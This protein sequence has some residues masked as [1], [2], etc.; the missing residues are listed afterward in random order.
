MHSYID[1]FESPIIWRMKTSRSHLLN[2]RSCSAVICP[3]AERRMS[4]IQISE[5][6][7]GVC[8]Q[9]SWPDPA[10]FPLCRPLSQSLHLLHLRVFC[11]FCRLLQRLAHICGDFCSLS[12]HQV[13]CRGALHQVRAV[14]QPRSIHCQ[15]CFAAVHCTGDRV[16]IAKLG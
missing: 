2:L 8:G 16:E 12:T 6:L 10:V 15:W 5:L 4:S 9:L 1:T 14:L 13:S 11:L 3:L 7:A